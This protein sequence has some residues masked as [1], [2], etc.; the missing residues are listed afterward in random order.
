MVPR[1]IHDSDLFWYYLCVVWVPLYFISY[2]ALHILKHNRDGQEGGDIRYSRTYKL[3][4]MILA[5]LMVVCIG[6]AAIELSFIY[7]SGYNDIK[8]VIRPAYY[9]LAALAW[10]LCFYLVRFDFKRRLKMVRFGQPFFWIASGPLFIIDIFILNSDFVTSDTEIGIFIAFYTLAAA[11]NIWLTFISFYRPDDFGNRMVSLY[12]PLASIH[13]D[14]DYAASF[15]ELQTQVAILDYKIKMENAKPVVYYNIQVSISGSKYVIRRTSAD[16]EL[17]SKI[18]QDRIEQLHIEGLTF[19]ELAEFSSREN[20]MSKIID[21]LDRFLKEACKPIYMF[22]ELCDFFEIPS[23]FRDSIKAERHS[24]QEFLKMTSD[25]QSSKISSVLDQESATDLRISQLF[26]L[27]TIP[28]F[29]RAG[30]HFEYAIHWKSLKTGTVGSVAYRFNE[31]YKFNRN[32]KSE[33]GKAELP[34]FPSRNVIS[35]II[36][37]PKSEALAE[38]SRSLAMYYENL[39][40][41]PAYLCEALLKFMKCDI[42]LDIIWSSSLQSVL[43]QLNGPV[44]WEQNFN[45]E[46]KPYVSY[47][48]SVVKYQANRLVGTW[49]IS[50]RYSEFISLHSNL[51]HRSRSPMLKRYLRFVNVDKSLSTQVP[52]IP[53]KSFKT[54]QD[55]KQIEER[56]NDLQKFLENCFFLRHIVD[57]YCFRAFLEEPRPSVE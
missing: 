3:K 41:D 29:T 7:L 14:S 24:L 11:F 47:I 13:L 37:E 54:L 55:P 25:Y 5:F 20:S 32:L 27:V 19:P 48:F 51:K 40:N 43:L 49:T 31:L 17:I 8:A 28:Q 57:S 50:R 1:I 33:I 26:F 16:I 35:F 15:A 10:S 39:M 36:S 22:E 38:R 45:D 4:Q 30:D 53:G 2:S 34:E 12:E 42:P 18:L 23:E 56:T 6:N 46:P 52:S 21:E 9:T 44:T